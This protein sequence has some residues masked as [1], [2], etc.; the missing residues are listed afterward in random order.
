MAQAKADAI[1]NRATLGYLSELIAISLVNDCH[2]S[3]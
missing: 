2:Q 3:L 1:G